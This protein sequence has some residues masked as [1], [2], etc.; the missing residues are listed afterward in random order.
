MLGPSA[1]G[2]SYGTRINGS[3][4]NDIVDIPADRVPRLPNTPSPAPAP[5]LPITDIPNQNPGGPQQ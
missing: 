1:D 2:S 5:N 3:P 4:A